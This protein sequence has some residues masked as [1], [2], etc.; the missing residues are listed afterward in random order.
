MSFDQVWLIPVM[1]T[2]LTVLPETGRPLTFIVHGYGVAAPLLGIVITPHAEL[3]VLTVNPTTVSN[4]GSPWHNVVP[5]S[6]RI[7]KG[8]L[9]VN[10]TVAIEEYTGAQPATCTNTRYWVVVATLVKVCVFVMFEIL[11]HEP[12]PLVENSQRMIVPL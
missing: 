10:T 2:D 11:V 1:V 8:V 9:A 4:A 7:V 3:K 12:P 5:A 6:E